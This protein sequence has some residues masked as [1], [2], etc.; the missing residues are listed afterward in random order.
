MRFSDIQERALTPMDTEK[1]IQQFSKINISDL[2]WKSVQE[3]NWF[4]EHKSF[5]L[6]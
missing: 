2:C 6:K 4:C 5:T 3:T 1:R